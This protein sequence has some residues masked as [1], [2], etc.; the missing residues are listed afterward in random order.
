MMPRHIATPMLDAIAVPRGAGAICLLRCAFA[1]FAAPCRHAAADAVMPR[2]AA[3]DALRASCPRALIY[4]AFHAACRLLRLFSLLYA[5][6]QRY[7]SLLHLHFH[8]FIR[9][10]HIFSIADYRRRAIYFAI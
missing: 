2:Y 7:F 3:A 9:Q 10:P 5:F 4:H 1:V 8:L 6:P